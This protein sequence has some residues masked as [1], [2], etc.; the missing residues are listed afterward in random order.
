MQYIAYF[1]LTV[2]AMTCAAT[3]IIFL[4]IVWFMIKHKNDF[5]NKEDW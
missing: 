5:T 3:V 1:F 2:G 4:L